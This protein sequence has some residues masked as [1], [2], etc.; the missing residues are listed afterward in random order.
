MDH[1]DRDGREHRYQRV[2]H[3]R[4]PAVEAEQQNP[5]R[6]GPDA[7]VEVLARHVVAVESPQ[8]QLAQRV[9]QQQHQQAHSSG[10]EQRPDQ[11]VG[12]FAEVARAE[13]LRRQSAGPHA[14]ERAVPVDE[15]EDRHADG[16]RADRCGRIRTPVPG[17]R[18]RDDA[19]ERHG[20]VRDDIGERNAQYFT[21]H[22]H[23]KR[24]GNTRQTAPGVVY[25]CKDNA[26]AAN[27]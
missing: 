24:R 18:R 9:L 26:K 21:V 14:H 13:R 16:Q 4:K 12:A 19:H 27:L 7:G 25:G 3:S 20:D 2:L 15:V 10:H 11:H 23:G 6:H 8:G 5:R 22:V 17:D 1:V